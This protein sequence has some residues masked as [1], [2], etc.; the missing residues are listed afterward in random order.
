[1]RKWLVLTLAITGCGE[2][3]P[4]RPHA[5]QEKPLVPTVADDP[6]AELSAIADDTAHDNAARG[7]VR[8]LH[9]QGKDKQA[10]EVANRIRNDQIRA[11]VL[12]ELQLTN[13]RQIG[14]GG[15]K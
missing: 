8:R 6:Y 9:E 5:A 7:W 11:S 15:R 14:D 2:T 3:G 4:F 13:L 10:Q 1:M 12:T